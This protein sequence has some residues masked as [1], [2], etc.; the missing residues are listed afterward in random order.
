[1]NSTLKLITNSPLLPER[2]FKLESM[3]DITSGSSGSITI[4]DFQY[5]KHSL[6][7]SIKVNLDQINLDFVQSNNVNYITI[8]NNTTNAKE[9]GYFVIKKNWLAEKTIQFDLRLDT[10]NS[11]GGQ[12]ELSNR[13]KILRQHKDRFIVEQE[14]DG[15]FDVEAIECDYDSDNYQ[16]Y[17]NI[18][19]RIREEIKVNY[20][21]D[22]T[23]Y[24]EL[25]TRRFTLRINTEDFDLISVR[26]RCYTLDENY[27]IIR[28][29]DDAQV[30]DYGVI[31]DNETLEPYSG[32]NKTLTAEE[33][34]L[35][36]RIEMSV[37]NVPEEPTNEY[38]HILFGIDDPSDY[39]AEELETTAT[40]L[41]ANKDLLWSSADFND[42]QLWPVIDMYSEGIMPQLYGKDVQEL[43]NDP[44]LDWYLVYMNQNDP[45]DSLVNPVFTYLLASDNVAITDYDA[46]AS[47]NWGNNIF[48]TYLTATE[49]IDTPLNPCYF[50]HGKFNNG[51]TLNGSFYDVDAGTTISQIT[52]YLAYDYILYLYRTLV[53]GN[54]VYYLVIK[55]VNSSSGAT[56]HTYLY[57]CSDISAY[58]QYSNITIVLKGDYTLTSLT[59]KQYAVATELI[60][61]SKHFYYLSKYAQVD[62]TD[63]KII[64]I[65]EMPYL[66]TPLRKNT[67]IVG[68]TFVENKWSFKNV[69]NIGK[70]MELS[71]NNEKLNTNIL[72]N[73]GEYSPFR[74]LGNKAY[75]FKRVQLKSKTLEPKLYHSDYYQPKFVYDSFGFV[76][77]LELITRYS[78]S[79]LANGVLNVN[80]YVSTTINSRF[81]FEFVP[82]NCDD[83]E[84]QDYNKVMCIARNNEM[85]LYN[86]QYINYLRVGYNYEVK[87]K[88][89]TEAFAWLGAGLSVAGA[90]V[91]FASSVYTGGFG[92][93]AGVSLAT[94]ALGTIASAINTTITSERQ[95]Q[96]KQ[97]QLKNQTTSVYGS[98]D[99][100]IMNAYAKNRLKLKLYKTSERMETLL[101]D[102][103]YFTGYLFNTLGVPDTT[104]RS[105]FNFV[106]AEIIL[107][108]VP[109]LSEEIIN[110]IKARYSIGITFLHKFNGSYDFDQIYENWENSILQ[111]I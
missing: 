32:T 18:P 24:R 11:F 89:R 85:P 57:D 75:T 68:Y 93:V 47:G 56:E 20:L 13:T 27:K 48:R 71:S 92:V 59:S 8:T 70:V 103:F 10:I 51:A 37:D 95:L 49:D 34:Y 28:Q 44:N 7:L 1:M 110:D 30:G 94:T 101:Y 15:F 90:V 73:L 67:N 78:Y 66:P 65:I 41:T 50:I 91:A 79:Y 107:K 63:P 33:K 52:I 106:C 6:L 54:Y 98:D 109:N 97:D 74:V 84:L 45:D 2:N 14:D 102:L 23:N 64:K 17:S 86:Q 40:E 69:A 88:Q 58:L 31:L 3:S 9:I 25:S 87:N 80:F 72:F 82:Y 108:K 105:R 55:Q 60:G 43:H 42:F 38:I 12:I 99:V 81:M 61:N 83:K 96:Q 21:F 62:R 104:S 35:G 76:F 22:L 36:F 53:D 77:Q 5:I 100:D 29:V 111:A 4:N 39:S 16:I 46:K 19:T 26:V